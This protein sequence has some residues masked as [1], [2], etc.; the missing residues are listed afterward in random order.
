MNY[1][2]GAA[3]G[4][5]WGALCALLNC[6]VSLRAIR[7]NSEKAVLGANLVRVAVDV[8]ALG[9]LFLLRNSLPFS[10]ET[11]LVGTAAS[12]SVITILFAFR[13][14]AGKIK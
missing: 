1:V 9:S 4:L 10:V 12:L 13:V 11:A 3:V 14:A 2:I 8:A 5:V 7:K 6:A